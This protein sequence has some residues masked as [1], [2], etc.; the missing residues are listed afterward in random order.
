MK[1]NQI[2]SFALVWVDQTPLRDRL[3]T[4]CQEAMTRLEEIRERWH[5][6]ERKDRPAFIRWRA[7]EFGVLLSEAREVEEKIRAM[8]ELIH[9]VEREMRRHFQSPQSAYARVKF[10]Q[11]NPGA[12]EPEPELRSGT[13]RALTEFEQEA[14]F[15]EWVQKFLGTNPDKMDDDA[16]EVSFESFK[17]HMFTRV[18]K[19]APSKPFASLPP[20]P[21]EAAEENREVDERVK[22]LYRRLV[23]QLHPDVRGDGTTDVSFLWHEA[24]EAYEAGDIARME[25]LLAL[26]HLQAGTMSPNHGVGHLLVVQRDLE[27]STRALEKSIREAR[28]EEAWDFAAV[29]ATPHLAKDVERQLKHDLAGRTKYLREL[30]ATVLQWAEP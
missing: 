24:Q 6:Y 18:T 5:R 26:S 23:R 13:T 2:V 27:R 16:Y 10:R 3:V 12:V 7:R 14:L 22:V 25:L 4:E 9:E 19:P 1:R 28:N 11:E 29:G 8:Q 17:A 21:E 15:R 30:E 20:S